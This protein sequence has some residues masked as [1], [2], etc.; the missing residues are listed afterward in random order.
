[1]V[2]LPVLV[3][4]REILLEINIVLLLEEEELDTLAEQKSASE[5]FRV[6]AISTKLTD[7]AADKRSIVEY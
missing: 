5:F 4:A 2:E 3:E 7:F 1:L 6:F